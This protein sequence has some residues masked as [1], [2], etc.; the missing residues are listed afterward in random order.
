MV[1]GGTSSLRPGEISLATNGVLFLDELGEFAPSVL[2]A[3][4]QPLEEGVVRVA[5]AKSS[6]VLPAKFLLVAATNPCPCGEGTPGLCVCDDRAKQKYLRRFSGPLLDRFDLRVAVTRPHVDELL[7][8][9][10]SESSRDIA[11]RVQ[12]A[13]SRAIERNGC[14]NSVLTAEALDE[15]APLTKGA[16]QLLRHQVERGRLSG[17]GYHRIRRVGRTVADLRDQSEKVDEMHIAVALALRV[18]VQPHFSGEQ[19]M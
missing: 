10:K 3:L 12:R 16:S 5:R 1:G 2:D 11:L 7:A 9:S 13:R 19:A 6:A 17:R 8:S 18:G 4:R 14:L 15:Y